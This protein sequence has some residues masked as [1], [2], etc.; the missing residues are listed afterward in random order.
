[1][2][3]KLQ[4]TQ[5]SILQRQL[6]KLS[7]RNIPT[8]SRSKSNIKRQGEA[9]A[10][11]LFFGKKRNAKRPLYNKNISTP[12]QPCLPQQPQNKTPDPPFIKQKA[13]LRFSRAR[14][15]SRKT[16]RPTRRS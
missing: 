3:Q 1:M 16:K 4:Q 7:T 11:L 5:R 10:P 15:T 2:P 12:F 8:A 13:A 9:A 14:R 6:R